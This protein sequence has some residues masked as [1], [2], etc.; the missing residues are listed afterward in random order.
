MTSFVYAYSAVQTNEGFRWLYISDNIQSVYKYGL[1]VFI[2]DSFNRIMMYISIQL[3]LAQV[4]SVWEKH[5]R[6]Q[7]NFLNINF[8]I[9]TSFVSWN[10]SCTSHLPNVYLWHLWGMFFTCPIPSILLPIVDLFHAV[11]NNRCL[12]CYN[13]S[14]IKGLLILHKLFFWYRKMTSWSAT[15]ILFLIND[16]KAMVVM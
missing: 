6:W 15:L 10:N 5:A 2:S 9:L 1:C 7:Y 8:L 3:R 4:G 11:L 13:V 12:N 14:C 16:L